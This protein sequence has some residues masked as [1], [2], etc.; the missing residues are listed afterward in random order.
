MDSVL[1]EFG[2]AQFSKFK[3][4]LADLAVEKLGPVGAEMKRISA[5]SAYI[6]GVLAEGAARARVIADETLSH[7]CE[8][9]GFV[10]P[11]KSI[12]KHAKIAFHD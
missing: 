7:V 3:N 1:K 11:A 6:D 9:A 4:A 10:R 8:I 12:S 2:G 5:D